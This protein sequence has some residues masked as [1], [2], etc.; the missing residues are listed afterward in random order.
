[1]ARLL[2]L[3]AFSERAPAHLHKHAIQSNS[4]S[5]WRY[6]QHRATVLIWHL[7]LALPGVAPNDALSRDR[8]FGRHPRP[9]LLRFAL[10]LSLLAN[11][12]AVTAISACVVFSSRALPYLRKY[13]SLR[14]CVH[15]SSLGFRADAGRV[16]AV[17]ANASS[18]AACCCAAAA[19][20]LS[21]TKNL[22]AGVQACG[23]QS[24]AKNRNHVRAQRASERRRPWTWTWICAWGVAAMQRAPDS[25]GGAAH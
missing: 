22:T 13:A 10:T 23:R 24:G 1:M 18:V 19:L 6:V 15:V 11:E 2:S 3:S 8:Y 9:H 12:R 25:G 7:A 20:L 17:E 21:L 16:G 4:G 14:F 5:P